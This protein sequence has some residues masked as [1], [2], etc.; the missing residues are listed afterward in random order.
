MRYHSF[1]D[2]Q[3]KKGQNAALLSNLFASLNQYIVLGALMMLYANDVLGL[4]PKRISKI[5]AIVPLIALLRIPFL[6]AIQNFGR[7]KVLI[8][9]DVIRFGVLVPPGTASHVRGGDISS[10]S[11]V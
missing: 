5:L 1:T 9:A 8:V 10:P 4:Y 2:T 3:R 11:Q 6:Q 7:V